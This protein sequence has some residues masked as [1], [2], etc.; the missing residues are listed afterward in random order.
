MLACNMYAIYI[1]YIILHI[2]IYCIQFS[3]TFQYFC[4][5]PGGTSHGGSG[6]YMGQGHPPCEFVSICL[7]LYMYTFL[8]LHI[9]HYCLT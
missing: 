7:L 3:V 5:L 8:H 4:H 6:P 9:L 2:N 1:I